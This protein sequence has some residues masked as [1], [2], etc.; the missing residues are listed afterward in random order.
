MAILPYLVNGSLLRLP[1]TEDRPANRPL[2]Y[3]NELF[4][5]IWPSFDEA[6]KR[7]LVPSVHAHLPDGPEISLSIQLLARGIWGTPMPEGLRPYL[8]RNGA[9]AGDSLLIRLIDSGAGHCDMWFESRWRRDENALAAR[10]GEIADGATSSS[11]ELSLMG[12]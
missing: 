12:C 9:A 5:S 1:L 8:I 3:P 7:K 6:E 4:F 11:T 2:R 10:N